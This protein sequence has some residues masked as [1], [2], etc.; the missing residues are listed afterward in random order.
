M[1]AVQVARLRKLTVLNKVLVALFGALVSAINNAWT[2]SFVLYCMNIVHLGVP[3][4][5]FFCL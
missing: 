4:R 2:E 3:V 1:L 5:V